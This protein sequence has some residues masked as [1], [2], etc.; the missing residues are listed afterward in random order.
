M[1]FPQQIYLA[2]HG[3]WPIL[4]HIQPQLSSFRVGTNP[5]ETLCHA[6]VL[7]PLP[8]PFPTCPVQFSRCDGSRGGGEGSGDLE[9][10]GGHGKRGA[11]IIKIVGKKREGVN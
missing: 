3:I 8:S 4:A 6:L 5:N 7:S 10:G 11:Q 1:D 2:R 9:R